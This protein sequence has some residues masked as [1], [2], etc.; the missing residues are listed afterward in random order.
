MTIIKIKKPYSLSFLIIGI[1]LLSVVGNTEFQLGT[2]DLSGKIDLGGRL[3]NI[4][5]PSAKFGE[6]L[7]Y[8]QG[9]FGGA[10]ASLEK[11]AYHLDFTAYD[12]GRSDQSY[13]LRGGRY[14]FFKY[15]L[16]YCA[17]Q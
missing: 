14:E 8:N 15:K 7:N 4:S 13:V 17:K 5:D 10:E 11:D 12:I 3:Q 6:Y 16:F 2:Y 9:F 1:F